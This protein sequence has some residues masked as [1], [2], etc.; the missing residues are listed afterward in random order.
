MEVISMESNHSFPILGS[1]DCGCCETIDRLTDGSGKA[2]G[3]DERSTVFTHREEEVLN[4]LRELS[5]KARRVKEQIRLLEE[6]GSVDIEAK[7]KAMEELEG[8][9]QLRLQLDAERI[10]AAEER[11]RL[12]G[13]A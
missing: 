13:H 3:C 9:R 11:M 6:A 12:L 5:P 7:R 10:A 1:D 8:L 4:R 2:Y